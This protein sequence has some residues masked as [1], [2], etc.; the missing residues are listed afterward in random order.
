MKYDDFYKYLKNP[1]LIQTANQEELKALCLQYPYFNLLRWIHLKSLHDIDSIYYEKELKKTAAHNTNRRNLFYFIYPEKVKDKSEFS[2]TEGSGSYFDMMDKLES[3]G[4]NDKMSLSR[5]AERLRTARENLREKEI[6]MS[7]AT[8]G[9]V[10]LGAEPSADNF[11]A[12]LTPEEKE[13]LVK[14]LIREEKYSSAIEKLEELSLINPKKS[15]YFADQ[16]QF[17]KRIIENK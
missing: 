11:T 8:L 16:I 3:E 10:S 12:G 4:K 14:T 17:L 15:I 6:E 2:R 5:L 1:E 13:E 9:T 7:V